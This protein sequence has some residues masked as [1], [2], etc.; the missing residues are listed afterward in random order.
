MG[1][2]YFGS[3]PSAS[4]VVPMWVKVSELTEEEKLKYEEVEKKKEEERLASEV[5]ADEN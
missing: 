4:F 1:E 3:S 5:A 2:P